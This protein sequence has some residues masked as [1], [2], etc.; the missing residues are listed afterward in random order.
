MNKRFH[1]W[2]GYYFWKYGPRAIWAFYLACQFFVATEFARF[3]RIVGSEH[4]H[5]EIYAETPEY[6]PTTYATGSSSGNGTTSSFRLSAY[7]SL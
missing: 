1:F 6:S 5:T 4:I 3:D 7:G 2:R